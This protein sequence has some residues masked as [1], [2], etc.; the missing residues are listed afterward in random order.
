VAAAAQRNVFKDDDPAK[1][2]VHC[3]LTSFA[4]AT[5]NVVLKFVSLHSLRLIV[6]PTY[7]TSLGTHNKVTL[8]AASDSLHL[9]FNIHKM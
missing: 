8:V 5:D 2:T 1:L 3:I 7:L 6:Q 4:Q 9:K